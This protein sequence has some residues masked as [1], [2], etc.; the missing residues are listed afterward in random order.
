MGKGKG[1]FKGWIGYVR[2]GMPM[3]ETGFVTAN[4]L[5]QS[6][7]INSIFTKKLPFE[8]IQQKFPFPVEIFKK[9]YKYDF[10]SKDN[11]SLK[12]GLRKYKKKEFNYFKEFYIKK[13]SEEEK[14]RKKKR[15][16]TKRKFKKIR[17]K[18]EKKNKNK[19]FF[20]KLKINLNLFFKKNINII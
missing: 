14:K 20:F 10:S 16:F 11:S 15:K 6:S 7:D 5:E 3:Y 2:P 12:T 18:K 9:S 8:K 17:L 13:D 4:A 1:K 19:I